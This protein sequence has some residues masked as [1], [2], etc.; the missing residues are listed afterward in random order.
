V[1][2][3]LTGERAS[4]YISLAGEFLVLAELARRRL[5][6]TLTLGSSKEIDILVLNRRTGRTFTVEVK[7]TEGGSRGSKLFRRHYSWLMNAKHGWISNKNLVYCFVLLDPGPERST[8]RRIF[9]V[10][11]VEVARYI[12]WNQKY[13]EREQRVKGRQGKVSSLRQF[14]VPAEESAVA[15][16]RFSPR[17][18]TPEKQHTTI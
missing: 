6:G 9:L 10:P 2:K 16:P 18:A 13:W 4:R 5:D 7:T 14:R 11:A 3:Q 15:V 8:R 1:T 17:G 12:R